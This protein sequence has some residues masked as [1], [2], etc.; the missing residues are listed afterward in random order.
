MYE[1][2]DPDAIVIRLLVSIQ[3]IVTYPLLNHFQRTIIFNLHFKNQGYKSIDD[4]PRCKFVAINVS[5]SVIP[6]LCALFYPHVGY[7]MGIF[8]SIS[9]LF[10][11]YIVPVMTYLKMIKMEI[12]NQKSSIDEAEGIASVTYLNN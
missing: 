12:T 8:A 3:I 2:S 5:I 4:L 10:M 11:I 7:I 6:L 1:Y 9:A